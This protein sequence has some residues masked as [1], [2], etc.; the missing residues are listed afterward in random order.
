MQHLQDV[1]NFAAL[2]GHD[3]TGA[4]LGAAGG[5]G[6][7]GGGGVGNREASSTWLVASH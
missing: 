6:G 7:G 3:R 4:S 1:S 2:C 5:G